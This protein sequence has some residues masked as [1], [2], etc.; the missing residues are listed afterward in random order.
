MAPKKKA[1]EPPAAVPNS[2]SATEQ[3]QIIGQRLRAA[4]LR[5]KMS[6]AELGSTVGITFQQIQKYEK[7]VNRIDIHRMLVLAKVLNVDLEYFTGAVQ[8]KRDPETASFDAVLASRHGTQ[9]I[10]AMIDLTDYQR[11]FLIEFA[12]SLPQLA[13][14]HA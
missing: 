13:E 10:E 3:H 5:A 1:A 7:G 11:Q 4:R 2:R 6:Q 12:R 9:I 14:A 8:T